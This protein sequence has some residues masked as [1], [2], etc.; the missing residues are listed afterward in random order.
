MSRQ[1]YA[2]RKRIRYE[3]HVGGEGG[4]SNY[5]PFWAVHLYLTCSNKLEP[6]QWTIMLISYLL[7]R[8]HLV[9]FER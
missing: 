8:F 9:V 4:L 1:Q 3:K 7:W 2:T 6:Q 5:D